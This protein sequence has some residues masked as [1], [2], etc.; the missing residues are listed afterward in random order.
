MRSTLLVLIL[1]LPSIGYAQ[2]DSISKNILSSTIDSIQ[3]SI[4]NMHTK[5]MSMAGNIQEYEFE[6]K[7]VT[8]S[9]IDTELF[10]TKLLDH[11]SYDN[12]RALTYHYNIVFEVFHDA[13]IK[14]KIIL[15]GMTGNID[16]ENKITGEVLRNRCTSTLGTFLIQLMDTHSLTTLFNEYELEG[17]IND[18]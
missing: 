2:I 13:Q 15:S 5:E 16:I 14:N 9:K 10:I 6:I 8:L 17:L 11:Q 7:R 1:T 12:S 18:E 3:C 4:W